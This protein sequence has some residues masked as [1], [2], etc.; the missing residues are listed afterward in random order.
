MRTITYVLSEEGMSLHLKAVIEDRFGKS[1]FRL[2]SLRGWR[3]EVAV[4]HIPQLSIN[5]HRWDE[6]TMRAFVGI[7]VLKAARNPGEALTF[8][9][10]VKRMHRMDVYF[11]TCTILEKGRKAYKAWRILYGEKVN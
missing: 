1:R 7:H 8:L 9:D 11:W 10:I 5:P 4:K 2:G 6:K 3:R